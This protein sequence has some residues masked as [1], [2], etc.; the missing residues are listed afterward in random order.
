MSPSARSSVIRVVSVWVLGVAVLALIGVAALTFVTGQFNL[1]AVDFF[2]V[3]SIAIVWSLAMGSIA[4]R[5]CRGSRG[6]G[7]R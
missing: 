6:R 7:G 4:I 3:V 5:I 1:A 2:F